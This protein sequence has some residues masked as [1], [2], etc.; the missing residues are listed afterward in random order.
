MIS[1]R[2]S[3]SVLTSLPVIFAPLPARAVDFYLGFDG[4]PEHIWGEPGEVMT[5]DVYLTL[6]T[7]N[8]ESPEGAMGW[9]LF[10]KPEGGSITNLTFKGMEV[11]TIYDEDPDLDPA[12]PPIH[13]DPYLFDLGNS[14]T[15]FAAPTNHAGQCA[16][17]G[18]VMKSQE[19]MV[20][21]PT[22]TQR[23]G[24]L[25]VQGRIPTGGECGTLQILYEDSPVGPYG[26]DNLTIEA[27]ARNALI[28]N[29]RE[30]RP[31]LGS[32]SVLLCPSVFHRGDSNSDNLVDISDAIFIL[33]WLF[34]AGPPPACLDAADVNDEGAIDISDVVFLLSDLFLPQNGSTIPDP[35]PYACGPDPT[36]DGLGCER[37][38]C[39]GQ[40]GP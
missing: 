9:V 30:M 21:Q 36:G 38:P 39:Q 12:T 20:L 14:F 28:W 19:K 34:L 10:L 5:F 22:G 40:G 8:N 6:F 11:S 24:K 15:D 18:V 1:K 32:I 27:P 25:S 4:L 2:L 17:E 33:D 26:C 37:S 35:G 13:H 31:V 29:G 16:V 23:I 7:T 3:I